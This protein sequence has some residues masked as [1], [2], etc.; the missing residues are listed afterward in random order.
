MCRS[1]LL[2]FTRR[3]NAH[4]KFLNYLQLSKL[5]SIVSAHTRAILSQNKIFFS[6]IHLQKELKLVVYITYLLR[7]IIYSFLISYREVNITF[8]LYLNI[9][10]SK[11]IHG[12]L[13]CQQEEKRSPLFQF[14]VSGKPSV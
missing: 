9:G 7:A 11:W 14:K 1:N 3:N 8:Y 5:L 2:L 6:P 10:I 13:P 12:S 4:R